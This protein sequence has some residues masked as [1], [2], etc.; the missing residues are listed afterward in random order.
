MSKTKKKKGPH[1]NH[2]AASPRAP[3]ARAPALP[4]MS[5]RTNPDD[6]IDW[7]AIG[8]TI[9]GAA[10]GAIVGAFAGTHSSP[11]AVSAAMT[12]GGVVG[13]ALSHG[14]VRIA[15]MGMLGAGAG[16][17]ALTLMTPK[18]KRNGVAYDDDDPELYERR[19]AALPEP[20][21][22][23]AWGRAQQNVAALYPDDDYAA[24]RF[25]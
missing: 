5:Q 13:A 7:T 1:R 14:T 3:S 19:Q 18:P 9:A 22:R 15:S 24:H 20:A 2:H 23:E 4:R 17:L 10:G 21:L 12:A 16:Q 25:D 6:P 11:T 8:A